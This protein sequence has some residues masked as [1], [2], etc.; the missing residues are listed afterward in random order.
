MP[1]ADDDAGGWDR[2]AVG[3][4][5]PGVEEASSAVQRALLAC[6]GPGAAEEI[7]QA[8][9][10]LAWQEVVAEAGL[11]R[12]PWSSRLVRVTNGVARVEAS[13][14][15][16]ASELRLRGDALVWAVNQRMAGRPGA[17]HRVRVLSVAV[18]RSHGS[19]T[20]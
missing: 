8:Q 13:E 11:D 15:M 12:G 9:A 14:A 2:R 16:L 1:G 20:L 5:R 18:G 19:A 4:G 6:I 3:P 17:S 7:A 10:R